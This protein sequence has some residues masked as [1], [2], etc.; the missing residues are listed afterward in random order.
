PAA[1]LH[2]LDRLGKDLADLR[3][4]CDGRLDARS[5]EHVREAPQAHADPIFL[6]GVV[7]DVGHVIGG[8]GSDADAEGGIVLPNLHIGREPDCERVVARPFE[9]L[10]LGDERVVVALRAADRPRRALRLGGGGPQTESGKARGPGKAETRGDEP[11][12]VMTDALH[13]DVLPFYRP[14]MSLPRLYA[15]CRSGRRSSDRRRLSAPLAC[16]LCP[17]DS[18]VSRHGTPRRHAAARPG[19]RHR[20]YGSMLKDQ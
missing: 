13:G 9:C 18:S 3:I 16:I 1:L 20:R 6:P 10:A 14:W 7:E 2:F 19:R 17:G 4:Q 12:T 8:I 5:V 15:E 11:P